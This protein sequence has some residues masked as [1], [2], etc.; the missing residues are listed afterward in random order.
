VFLLVDSFFT[1][2][3]SIIYRPVDD[4]KHFLFIIFF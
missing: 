4:V 1:L 3:G 2:D